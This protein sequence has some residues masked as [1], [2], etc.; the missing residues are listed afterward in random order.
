MQ[1]F[2]R[3]NNLNVLSVSGDEN[4]EE[5]K[6]QISV[7]EGIPVEDQVLFFAGK[8]LESFSTLAESG[9]QDSST[10]DVVG[11]VLGGRKTLGISAVTL[12]SKFTDYSWHRIF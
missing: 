7:L 1:L 2:V 12:L 10:L 5:L 9:I 11:R 6:Q 4:V 8:P 3:G